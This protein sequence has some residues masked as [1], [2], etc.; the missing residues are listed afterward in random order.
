M[1]YLKVL[2]IPLF[3][4][5]GAYAAVFIAARGGGSFVGLFAMPV[6]MFCIPALLLIGVLNARGNQP[7]GTAIKINLAIAIVP[8]AGLLILRALES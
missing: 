8:A 5:L 2:F 6:A 7:L 3:V 4:Q 1:R